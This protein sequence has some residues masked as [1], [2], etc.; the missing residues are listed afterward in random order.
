MGE[1]VSLLSTRKPSPLTCT[2]EFVHDAVT[3]TRYLYP[4]IVSNLGAWTAAGCR[5]LSPAL[6]YLGGLETSG[7]QDR[8]RQCGLLASAIDLV[9][10]ARDEGISHIH[11]HSCADAA[12]VLAL[13]RRLGGPSYS[14]TLHGDLDVYGTDHRS[15]MG[16]AAFIST[17]GS[18]LRRQV[19]ERAGVP[20]E[21]VFVTCMGVETS[22]LATLGKDRSFTPG[23]LHLVTVARLHPVKGH[24]HALAAVHRGLQTGLDLRYTIAGE[25]PY[26]DALLARINELGLGTRVTL[27]GTLSESEVYTLLS[28]AD[29]FVLPSIG[30]GEAWP[31]AVMEA[32]GAGLPVIA[33]VIGATPEMIKQGV[34]GLLIPQ[35]DERA[36]LESIALLAQDVDTRRR[37]GEAGRRTAL[38][39]FDVAATA[40]ALRDAFRTSLSA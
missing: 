33:S 4:P 5:G 30:L 7:F 39:R 26:R 17:V 19:L 3:E 36:L 9:R 10:W 22:E 15:K 8:L 11:G 32:M 23:S 40:G 37:I 27:T 14:L 6:T 31:V 21:R 35:K 18:H 1:E 24:D 29:A 2:H 34:D 38:R 13:A 25:G 12:H 16:G 20:A 28:N